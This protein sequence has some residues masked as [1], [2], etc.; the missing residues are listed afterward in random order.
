MLGRA[1]ILADTFEGQW[2]GGIDARKLRAAF[3]QLEGVAPPGFLIAEGVAEPVAAASSLVIQGEPQR[4]GFLV[5][6][7]G[8]GTTDF[9]MFVVVIA[10]RPADFQLWD[11]HLR[12]RVSGVVAAGLHG[13][14]QETSIAV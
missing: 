3:N 1:Q 5:I 4:T 6:D 14:A 7:V 9:G 11:R 12:W 10:G 2:S 13:S 8:A